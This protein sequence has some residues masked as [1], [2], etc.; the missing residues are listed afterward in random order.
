VLAAEAL[1][2]LADELAVVV[3]EGGGVRLGGTG[4]PR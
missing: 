1:A 4:I 3:E 2:V